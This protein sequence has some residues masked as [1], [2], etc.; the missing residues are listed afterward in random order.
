MLVIALAVVLAVVPALAL[1]V[2]RRGPMPAAPETPVESQPKPRAA[3]LAAAVPAPA[4]ISG[5]VERPRAGPPVR[6]DGDALETLD[7]LLAELESTTV[8]I[9]G[10]D[11]LDE[12]SVAELEGLAE[13]LE[14][15]AAAI[16]AR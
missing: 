1:V 13:R 11:A 8:R 14:E 5:E 10:A 4:T 15:A 3:V 6:A 16:A 9:D 7:A 12:G 2:R